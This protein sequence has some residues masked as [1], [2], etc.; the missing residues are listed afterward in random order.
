MARRPIT[1]TD[2]FQPLANAIGYL[3]ARC[4]GAI[5]KDGQ[6]FD[7]TDTKFG[8]RIADTPV[9]Q[10]TREIAIDVSSILPKY[11]SQLAAGGIDVSSLPLISDPN[12]DLIRRE[13]RQQAREKEYQRNH[14]PYVT[15]VVGDNETIVSVWNSFPIKDQL[16]SNGFAFGRRGTKTW[17]AVL[18]PA[19]ASAILGIGSIEF[20]DRQKEDL[21]ELADKYVPAEQPV[22]VAANTNYVIVSPNNPDRLWIKTAEWST[23]PIEIMRALPGRKW[24]GI[25][26]VNE[27]DPHI[28]VERTANEFGLT[29]HPNAKAAI[30]SHR[31]EQLA[32]EA[33]L[34]ELVADSKAIDTDVKVA[35][36]DD[37]YKF[38]R[39]G[40]AYAIEHKRTIFGDDMGLGKTRQA[41]SAIET[42]NAYPALIICPPNLMLNWYREIKML[43]PNRT[44]GV[45]Q[46]RNKNASI[47]MSKDIMIVGYSTIP[48][49]IQNLPTNLAALI[50]DESHYIKNPKASRTKAIAEIAGKAV[51]DNRMPIPAKLIP[52]ALILML[53]GT[54]ILNR[55]VELVE[56]LKI[57]GYLVEQKGVNR[58]GMM[59]V[60]RYLWRYCDPKKNGSWGTTFN[61]HS[62]E[63][64]LHAWLRQTCM[65]R[66][67]KDQVLTDLPAKVRSP[68]FVVLP[69]DAMAKYN[70]LAAIGAEKA[71]ASRAEALVYMNELRKATGTAKIDFAVEW[72]KQFLD[73]GKSLVVFADHINVQNALLE[74][75]TGYSVEGTPV[76]VTHIRGGQGKTS[77]EDHKE[78]F[79]SGDSKLMI[80]SISAGKEGHTLT[81][82]SDVLFVEMGWNPG[83]HDQAEDRCHRI[84]QKDSVTAWWLV[85]QMTHDEDTY[86]LIE[87][88]RKVI[89]AVHDGKTPQDDQG[90]VFNQVLDR[91]LARHGA[92]R[93]WD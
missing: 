1:E 75:F 66:R 25:A 18:S 8:R 78:K 52:N 16:K 62:N 37:L 32:E 88:K 38:Q 30:D 14:A 64:E 63:L 7:G 22:T 50:C 20:T 12:A 11:R 82:A 86:E 21:Q 28:A 76:N 61:G 57:M 93:E 58:P 69:D 54:P 36:W 43:L 40:S 59:S 9:D 90:S 48:Y 67:T 84:G 10:W 87:E 60:G 13:A 51:D 70:R 77:I 56:P 39:A 92:R 26:K 6:G 45:Y 49:W 5:A 23:V 65:V 79:Q 29:I 33:K 46:G 44:V 19:S 24:N 81:A 73:T 91:V 3:A 72:I 53:T 80:V 35:L 17:D 68:Q 85:C 31:A 15:F 74:A 83:T 42:E 71:A 4:D 55:P 34:E 41:L 47:R 89:N 2:A 27:V